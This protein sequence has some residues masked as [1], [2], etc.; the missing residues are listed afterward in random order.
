MPSTPSLITKHTVTMYGR[1]SSVS[2]E[3][4]FWREIVRMAGEA[5]GGIGKF[6]EIIDEARGGTGNLS[7]A[8][9]LA[10]IDDL[11]DT[12]DRLSE[13]LAHAAE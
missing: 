6:V 9:R 10:V 11:K 2:L 13:N 3:A 7:S 8:L 12:I 5:G 4:S 1:R